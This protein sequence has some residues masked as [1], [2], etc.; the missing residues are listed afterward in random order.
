[1]PQGKYYETSLAAFRKFFPDV[2]ARIESETAQLEAIVEDGEI[3]DVRVGE[4]RLYGE[5]GLAGT[6]AQVETFV[7]DPRRFLISDLR[8]AG[9]GSPV[10]GKMI[11]RMY[12]EGKAL[13]PDAVAAEPVD[14]FF[15]LCVFGVGLGY[16]LQPLYDQLKPRWMFLVEPMAQLIQHSLGTVDWQTLL[17]KA[18][19]DGVE[20]ALIVDGD[21]ER[22]SDKIGRMISKRGSGF[23]EGSYIYQHYPLWT[24]SAARQ[25][26]VEAMRRR[27]IAAGFYEDELVMMT[28]A[29]ANFRGNSGHVIDGRPMRLRSEPVFIVGSGP[30]ADAAMPVIKRFRDQAVVVSCGSSLRILLKNGIVPNF[31]VEIENTPETVDALQRSAKF[32]DLKQVTLIC[33]CTVDPS[34]PGMFR[35][36][37]FF[38]RDSV[39]STVIMGSRFKDVFGGSP[40]VA[41]T[42]LAMASLMGFT[43][44]YFF[45]VDCGVLPGGEHHSKDSMY[46]EGDDFKEYIESTLKYPITVRGN[47]G[48]AAH[49][50]ITLNASR[51]LLGTVIRLR[52]LEAYNCSDG[53]LIEHT[54]PLLPECVDIAS[55]PIDWAAIDAACKAQMFPFKPGD[56]VTDVDREALVRGLHDFHDALIAMV[57]RVVEAEPETAVSAIYREVI[58]LEHDIIGRFANSWSIALGSVRTL[59]RIGMF[60]VSR[61]RDADHRRHLTEAFVE[62]YR[63]CLLE[64]RDGAEALVREK[65]PD[66][67][68]AAAAAAA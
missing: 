20:V 68:P 61:V 40:T 50:E 67:A 12:R 47:F 65:F 45:G 58:T 9:M 44:Y 56:V 52:G 3:I 34:V 53:C 4:K 37:V 60:F 29:T 42:A 1:M 32:G 31:H 57:D 21:P 8:K 14:G 66:A 51:S 36:A 49:T 35:E 39:S 13:G 64:M 18:E 55:P 59:P 15:F 5:D 30:S 28:N 11:E 26:L 6:Q 2:A 17:E 48:G 7:K 23:F 25:K 43:K 46:Y 27:F 22:I 41:N 62:Q 10:C 24:L 63:A 33:S 38:F 19:A 16:H 54:I